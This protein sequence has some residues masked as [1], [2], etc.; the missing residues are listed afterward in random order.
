MP[1]YPGLAY[2]E[3][4]SGTVV[5]RATVQTDGR[6]VDTSVDV[7][8]GYRALDEAALRAV[9]EARFNA[10]GGSS[11]KHDRTARIPIHFSSG[12]SLQARVVLLGAEGTTQPKPRKPALQWPS[13]YRHPQYVPAGT[14]MP[15]RDATKSVLALARKSPP[16]A[17]GPRLYAEFVDA[18]AGGTPKAIWFALDPGKPYGI[19]VRYTFAGAAEHPVVTVAA[20]C[21]TGPSTCAQSMPELL[22]GPFFARAA[23]TTAAAEP[24]Q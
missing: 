13:G 19:I 22:R 23:T 1:T 2:L 14:A 17:G 8:S 10:V 6:V 21:P 5:V 11:P 3:G 9:R 7:S 4:D 15:F 18:A 20:A 12:Q 16:V 24:D